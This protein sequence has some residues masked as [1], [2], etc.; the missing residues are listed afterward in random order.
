MEDENFIRVKTSSPA[1]DL[2]SYLAGLKKLS[3]DKGKKIIIYQRLNLIGIGFVGAKHPFQDKDGYDICMPQ[4]MFD[5]LYPLIKSQ[6]YIEDFIV[7]NGQ[8][9]EMDMD[10][11]RMEIYTNQPHGS[12]NRWFFHV[13][14]E[15]NCDLSK[16]WISVSSGTLHMDK[17]IINITD[18]YRNYIINYFFL[19]KYQ[20][21]IL[22]AGTQ[23]EY[24]RFCEQWG[25]DV[26]YLEVNN[27][28]ELAIAI[29][30]CKFFLGNQ[31]FCFQL[32]ES[33]KV[34]RILEISPH[35]PNVIPIGENAYDF[36]HQSEL[37][38][39]FEKLALS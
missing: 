21:K 12:L 16:E 4:S 5:M 3:K 10:K 27:F 28:L 30:S 14:P 37:E 36:Y 32:A 23:D 33:M 26:K 35:L 39:Y 7:Y 6:D 1:G 38:Y 18:R 11:C 31:S 20:D 29:K 19:K 24:N 8:E 34:P 22:F 25:V 17:I 15:M 13:Y 2:I 9:I